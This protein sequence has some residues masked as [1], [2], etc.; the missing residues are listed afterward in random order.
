MILDASASAIRQ[1]IARG[2]QRGYVTVDEVNA[3]LP[4]REVSSEFVEDT[5]TSLS[6]AGINVVDEDDGPE[7][8]V[9]APW[10]PPGP[11]SPLPLQ[12]GE[13]APLDGETSRRESD[14]SNVMGQ[15]D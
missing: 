11:L 3:A 6:E 5:L 4:S 2:K 1:L 13:E 7:D 8:G 9:T 15:T 12:A 10:N 14:F